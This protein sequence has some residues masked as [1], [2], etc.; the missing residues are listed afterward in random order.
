MPIYSLPTI[1]EEAM[2]NL[3]IRSREQLLAAL[4]EASEIEHNLM[5]CYLYALFS[6]KERLDED[7]LPEEFAAVNRWRGIIRGI[8]IEEM[9]H[10]T[11]VTNITSALGAT[12]HFLRPNFPV[13]PG[14]YPSGVV[15]ELAPF[16]MDTLDHFI[17]LERPTQAGVKDA[18]TFHAQ[19][20]SRG[21]SEPRLMPFGSDYATVGEL[22]E[23]IREG[24]KHL[25][26]ELGESV[27][28]CGPS[29]L[30]IGA[31][32]SA[33]PGLQQVCDL[34]SAN[35]AL[36]TIVIQGEGSTDSQD[37]HF[38]RFQQIKT[39]YLSLLEKREFAP[40]RPV[41]RNP[42]MRPPVNTTERLHI[43]AEPAASLIDL[44]NATYVQM[45]RVLQQL[46]SV[47][48]RSTES[49]KTLLG[50]SYLF[51]RA[52]SSLGRIL[53]QLPACSDAQGIAAGMS[54]ATIRS[55]TPYQSDN[56]ERI[57]L[58][59]RT[60]GLINT[61]SRL[62][63][64]GLNLSEALGFLNAAA[65]LL[66][67]AAIMK[68]E[69]APTPTVLPILTDQAEKELA[70]EPNVVE[71]AEGAI[72]SIDFEGRK[73]I[74]SR[75]CVLELPQVF[76]ANTPGQWIDPDATSAE[77]LVAIA[78]KC[79]SGA[80]RY[81]RND[82]N[83]NERAPLV[84]IL[85]IRENGPLAIRAALNLNGL[86]IGFRATLCRCGKSNNK[87]FCDGSH[88]AGFIASGE[89]PSG[90]VTALEL[91]DGPVSVS[92]QPN[93]PLSVSGNLEICA[94][95][96]RTVARVT[97]ALLCRCGHSENKPFCDGSHAVVGFIAK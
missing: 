53:T 39:E 26:D 43:T 77:K 15:I 52:M 4:G 65:D 86:D 8:A 78:E 93:G 13:S 85:N 68:S 22:Y 63:S 37:C 23:S 42:V 5:C 33:L 40:A 66:G 95:T 19:S 20:Y 69:A 6:M 70:A 38:S 56:A 36:D 92:P 55:L 16:C 24:I 76:K 27:L 96:G 3:Q 94:G 67:R 12:P 58:G 50:S 80:I 84:N 61:L 17:F 47:P 1:F 46:Y 45:L 44:A 30:Q 74:H 41:A 2:T 49:K 60:D 21:I 87:P 35:I 89:P 90:D 57:G 71:H 73:C 97:Q 91:R 18:P 32:D 51:M 83:P 72:I 59:E 29:N 48:T 62:E 9:S 88:V 10:L 79:P 54:F 64:A 82:G 81:S 34:A 31:T 28:F 7:L 25:A 11:L 14:L 75:H